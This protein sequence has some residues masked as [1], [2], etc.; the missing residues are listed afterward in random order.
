MIIRMNEFLIKFSFKVPNS[1]YCRF[2]RIFSIS[3][4]HVTMPIYYTYDYKSISLKVTFLG[5]IRKYEH[6]LIYKTNLYSFSE[7]A[8]D[9]HI[10]VNV[11][12]IH[13]SWLISINYLFTYCIT[14]YFIDYRDGLNLISYW[15]ADRKQF[16]VL[17]KV[18]YAI[19]HLIEWKIH[20]NVAFYWEK[21]VI[22]YITEENKSSWTKIVEHE[23]H[24]KIY[25]KNVWRCQFLN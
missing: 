19:V 3:M 22:L 14:W 2:I 6:A 21:S 18:N 11:V 10:W 16:K 23:W 17:Y 13:Q 12:K 1:S 4:S 15:Y 5:V 24:P 7:N 25:I 20:L 8:F 9:Y